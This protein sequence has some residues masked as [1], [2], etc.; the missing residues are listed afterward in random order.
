M[1]GASSKLNHIIKQSNHLN[2]NIF[3]EGRRGQSIKGY[4]LFIKI[5]ILADCG[6]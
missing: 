6:L 1:G 3:F 4:K 2:G 5:K